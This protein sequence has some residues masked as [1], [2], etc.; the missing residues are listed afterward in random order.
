VSYAPVL[1]C[2]KR[3][4]LAR[5]NR[6][7]RQML[8]DNERLARPCLPLLCRIRGERPSIAIK[9]RRAEPGSVLI[10]PLCFKVDHGLGRDGRALRLRLRNT[11][12]RRK[13]VAFVELQVFLE[14]SVGEGAKARVR[15]DHVPKVGS[16]PGSAIADVWMP[17]RVIVADYPE[18]SVA[19]RDFAAFQAIGRALA[20]DL[21]NPGGMLI[22]PAL[23][24]AV[25]CSLRPL[26][27]LGYCRHQGVGL[28]LVHHV[29]AAGN[30]AECAVGDGAVKAA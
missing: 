20:A 11:C 14:S 17:I 8:R 29:A 7:S 2:H 27:H 21:L 5:C 3:S 18:I 28:G 23:R 26:G 24:A 1:R 9:S 6:K 12:A 4:G 30:G 22:R 10:A 19:G 13:G 25:S 15:I 16:S